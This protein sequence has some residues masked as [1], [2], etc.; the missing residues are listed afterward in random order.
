M[1]LISTAVK[2][3]VFFFFLQPRVFLKVMESLSEYKSGTMIL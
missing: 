1:P 3:G 2:A